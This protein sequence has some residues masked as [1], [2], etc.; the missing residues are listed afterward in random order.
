MKLMK[1]TSFIFYLL[2]FLFAACAPAAVPTNTQTTQTDANVIFM[3]S[4]DPVEL[5]AYQSLVDAFHATHPELRV[6]LTHVPGDSDYRQKLAT[7][8]A[9]GNPP[10]VML[11][12][13]RRYPQFA[14]SGGLKPLTK[15]FDAS[16]VFELSDFFPAAIEA[17]IW[18]DELWCVPQNLSSLVVY[19]NQA[20]FDRA[21][22]EY[23]SPNWTWDDFLRIARALTLDNNGNG[24]PE[25]HGAGID[26]SLYRLA[27][28][29]WQNGGEIVD[30]PLAPT[31]LTLQSESALEA[32]RW[33]TE[34][35][36]RWQVVP[37]QIEEQSESSE[38]RFLNSKMAMYFSSRRF[39]PILRESVNFKW[40]VAP[41]PQGKVTAN[42]LHSD[43][44]C[45]AASAK[46]PQA[47]WAFIEFAN[48]PEGQTLM[49]AT[50]RTVPSLLAVAQSEAFLQPQAAPLSSRVFV[51]SAQ[52]MRRVPLHPKWIAVEEI[53][54]E[55]I[56]RAFYGIITPEEAAR[57]ADERTRELF[58]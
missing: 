20:L 37:N 19:Y 47:A 58:R 10:D 32:L 26:P 17:F 39:T 52:T 16:D 15:F 30:N 51:E 44:Y 28:F 5:A 12:N 48:S 45:M 6:A 2:M 41:L 36:T 3:V 23:P 33:F 11:L 25:Q 49:L 14:A 40:D 46:N 27:P 54:S 50:G 1:R 18:Q 42:V 31:H 24:V 34:L 57:L 22:L 35:Q 29:V 55:E 43:G 56:E 21:A 4:G 38:N 53:A 9:A 8:F 13:Y 7:L